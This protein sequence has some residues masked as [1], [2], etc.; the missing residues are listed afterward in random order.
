MNAHTITIFLEDG[1]WMATDTD[2]RTRELFGT[3]TLPTPFLA[4][5]PAADVLHV[6]GRLN[7]RATGTL[8]Q[9]ATA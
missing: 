5:T 8:R 9:E 1:G 7:P 2:P 6:L 4:D 3:D